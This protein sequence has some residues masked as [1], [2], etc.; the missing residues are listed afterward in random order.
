MSKANQQ[1]E[2]IFASQTSPMFSAEPEKQV[3]AFDLPKTKGPRFEIGNSAPDEV[4]LARLNASGHIDQLQRQYSLLSICS[5][6]V[7]IGVY[8][9]IKHGLPEL[10][11]LR[12]LCMGGLGWLYRRRVVKWRSTRHHMGALSSMHILLFHSGKYCGAR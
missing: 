5:T 9:Q 7:T 12:R 4:T 3:L 11:P 2:D 1:S 6:S 10:N 8:L